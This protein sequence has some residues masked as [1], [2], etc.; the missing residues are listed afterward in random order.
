MRSLKMQTFLF[1]SS[2]EECRHHQNWLDLQDVSVLT[3]VIST[4]NSG[5]CFFVCAHTKLGAH[6]YKTQVYLVHLLPSESF[7]FKLVHISTPP[8]SYLPHIS[9]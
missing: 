2:L 5:V 6:A 9:F 3:Y 1:P 7:I 8:V 4:A